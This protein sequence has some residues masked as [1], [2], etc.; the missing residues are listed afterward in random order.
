MRAGR[1]S[2]DFDAREVLG[3]DGSRIFFAFG[4][5]RFY[6]FERVGQAHA[7]VFEGTH[8]M[9]GEDFDAFDNG[10]GLEIFG[11]GIEARV[12]VGDTGNDDVAQ[13]NGFTDLL[14]V[15]EK[16]RIV[17]ARDT[18]VVFM[19]GVVDGFHVEENQVGR[20]GRASCRLGPDGA[21]RVERGV[22]AF[23]TAEVEE[24]LDKLGLHQ[25]FAAGAGDTA[26]F[27]EVFVLANFAQQFFGGEPV[28]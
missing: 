24:G 11:Q 13:P 28:S 4:G 8:G 23:G 1:A 27:D 6:A 15:V 21:G 12:V 16:A 7:F 2:K 26:R 22:N 3:K 5:E 18:N 9:V 25:R 14:Q 17:V 10:V 19:N 20:G